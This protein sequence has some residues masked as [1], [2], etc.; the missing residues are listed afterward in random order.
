MKKYLLTFLVFIIVVSTMD[1]QV[2]QHNNTSGDVSLESGFTFDLN[3]NV[4]N[5]FLSSTNIKYSLKKTT[6]VLLKVY[7]ILGEE[8]ATLVNQKQTAGIHNSIFYATGLTKGIYYY[9]ITVDDYIE[10]R[11]MVISKE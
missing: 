7:N 10:T 8:V 6:D 1:S 9:Q 2:L 3:Q 5:P 11:R 4:P